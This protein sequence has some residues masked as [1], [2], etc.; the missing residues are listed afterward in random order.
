VQEGVVDLGP[1]GDAPD[2]VGGPGLEA[3]E[4]RRHLG[5]RR[6][7]LVLVDQGVVGVA[8]VPQ[9]V[10]LFPGHRHQLGQVGGEG[11]KVVVLPGH[12]PRRLGHADQPGLPLDQFLGQLRR[13]FKLPA[14]EAHQGPVLVGRQGGLGELGRQG[15]QHRAGLGVVDQA[16]QQGQ[17]LGPLVDAIVGKVRFLVPLEDGFDGGKADDFAVELPQVAEQA[18]G[19]LGYHRNPESDESGKM[20]STPTT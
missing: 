6:P 1:G 5:R 12:G 17:L 9:V 18:F 19:G 10:G 20:T 11:G 8:V 3:V 2:Q 14:V 4:H 15:P 7:G 16:A 13:P